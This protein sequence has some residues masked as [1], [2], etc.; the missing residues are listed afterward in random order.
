[1]EHGRLVK[2]RLV[3]SLRTQR[4]GRTVEVFDDLDSTNRYV[5][6]LPPDRALDG[7]V[8]LAEHQGAGKGRHG[9][10]W[11]CPRGAGIL[12]TVALCCQ[13]DELDANLLSLVVPIAVC[14]GLHAATDVRC[15]I[16]WPNDIVVNRRKL[17]GVLIESRPDAEE[18][19]R[20][21]VGFGIN[22]LQHPGHFP[23]ELRGR[24]TSLDGESHRPIQRAD[25]LLSVLTALDAWL[26]RSDSWNPADIRACWKER[27]WGLGERIHVR[28]DGRLFAGN[29]IDIDPTAAILVQL[30]EG[31]RRLFHAANTTISGHHA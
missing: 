20:Y 25:V 15:E 31:G 13:P 4:I 6:D 27:A 5:L 8:V 17:A 23:P 29:L 2:E 3:S 10:S 30:D 26:A 14:D 19:T 16:K 22:C 18:S 28:H 11:H 24:A 1:M 9:R 12:C 21:A 7:L